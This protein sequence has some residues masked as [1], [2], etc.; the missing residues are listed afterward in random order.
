MLNITKKV[1]I[2]FFFL[3]LNQTVSYGQDTDIIKP[4][5]E[6][7]FS[8]FISPNNDG[9]NDTFTIL[10][11]ELYPNNE[12]AIYN[13]WGDLVYEAKPYL[14]D[15]GGLAKN[16]LYNDHLPEGVYFYVLKDGFDQTFNGK[17]TIK[18]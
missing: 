8:N 17:V 4:I 18:R 13:R 11:I 10:N 5:N 7:V 9:H 6:L 15:W 3:L 12:L 16:G 1:F 14:N 2:G